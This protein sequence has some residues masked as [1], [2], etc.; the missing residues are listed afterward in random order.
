MPQAS[1]HALDGAVI[2]G[3]VVRANRTVPC[4]PACAPSSFRRAAIESVPQGGLPI[5]WR[6]IVKIDQS[7]GMYLGPNELAD[8]VD[9][10]PHQR[11][12]MIRWLDFQGWKYVTSRTGFPK[13]SRVYHDKKLGVL[14]G[15]KLSSSSQLN[16][17]P[18]LDAFSKLGAHRYQSAVP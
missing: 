13:V 7:G 9:C 8:L 5:A 1:P 12:I 3:E 2:E 11:A 6:C 14:Q 18:Q 4:K 17:S 10:Q 15:S 16:S